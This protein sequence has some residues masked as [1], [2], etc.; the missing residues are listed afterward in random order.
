MS[1]LRNA[2]VTAGF[3][4]LSR[5]LGFARDL[6]RAYLL[7]AG[8][9]ADALTTALKFP[10]MFRRLFAE[11]A[12]AQGFVPLYAKTAKADPNAA[13]ALASESLAAL[14]ALTAGLTIAAQIAMPWIMVVLFPGYVENRAIFGL[15]VLL[16]QITMPYMA[17]MAI[18]ALLA[19]VLN[20]FGR[21]VLSAAAPTLLNLC[22]IAA[23][24]LGGTPES[25]A[26]NASIAVTLAGLLQCA[27]LWWGVRRSG[28]AL[29]VRWPR[30]TPQVW[31]VAQLAGPSA[32]AAGAVQ[33]N[34][35]IS[36]SLASFVEGGS[37]L[38]DYADR[39]Y[40]LPLGLVGI[41]IGTALI[42]RLAQAAA[43][44]DRDQSERNL[45]EAVALGM[46][47]A[48]PAATAL[49]VIPEFLM[50]G[51]WTRGAFTSADATRAG[52][53]LLHY[54]WGVPAFILAKILAP[55]FFA[56]EDTKTPTRFAL[57]SIVVNIGFGVV[58]FWAIGLAGLAIATSLAAWINVAQLALALRAKG[59]RLPRR[60]WTRLGQISAAC[61]GMAVF[62][63]FAAFFR[64]TIEAGIG[65]L[66]VMFAAY[67]KEIAILLVCGLGGAVYAILAFILGALRFDE[68]KRALRR[69]G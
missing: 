50:D 62:L 54:G 6:A 2:A 5:L 59:W 29:F 55:P 36:H 20:A 57:V 66:G 13:A 46:A 24:L 37:S 7:G 65:R 45:A 60:A 28:A 49:C 69:A 16:T 64:R 56:E 39:L 43:S 1:L 4:L 32:L 33:V 48:L 10:N 18:A 52:A 51:F 21:F 8:P 53:A 68:V 30:L 25:A 63:G 41:A 9:V 11:G 40:Q 35:F 23:F 14:T 27:A 42:P 58:L 44:G 22:M 38:L 47:F 17:C 3:T 26:R 19:G 31:R 67:D 15:A 12:F 61:L 34:I